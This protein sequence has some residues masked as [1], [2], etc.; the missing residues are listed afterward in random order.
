MVHFG[1][2]KKKRAP[3]FRNADTHPIIPKYFPIAQA[4]RL[5]PCGM[6][7]LRNTGRMA[8]LFSYRFFFWHLLALNWLARE[9]IFRI[10]SAPHRVNQTL[11]GGPGLSARQRRQVNH[12]P[13]GKPFSETQFFFD[14]LVRS[15]LLAWG[16]KS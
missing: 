1:P 3:A 5:L 15:N 9:Y 13:C 4:P 11:M 6:P 7:P 16:P 10:L 12:V 8:T 14:I 2:H